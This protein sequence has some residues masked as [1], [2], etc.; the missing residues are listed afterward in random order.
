M[1]IRQE[2]LFREPGFVS[3]QD[4]LPLIS[5]NTLGKCVNWFLFCAKL[6]VKYYDWVGPKT[7]ISRIDCDQNYSISIPLPLISCCPVS[8]GC[9][10][11]WLHLCRGVRP[12]PK[13]VSWY[14]TKQSDGEVPAVLEIWGMRRTPSLPLLP[15]PLWPGVVAPDRDLSMG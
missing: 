9:R 12:T 2:N 4:C 7:C 13:R 10:I 8:W 3:S 1:V 14:D 6:W 11:H 5:T 15:G